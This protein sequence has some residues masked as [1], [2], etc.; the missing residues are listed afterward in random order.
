MK[1]FKAYIFLF[2]CS[3]ILV[4]CKPKAKFEE[5]IEAKREDLL[6]TDKEFSILCQQEGYSR[7]YLEYIDS[8]GILLFP[9]SM[10]LRGGEAIDEILKTSDEG[11]VMQWEPKEAVV[12]AS[13]DIGY[14]YGVYRIDPVTG[15]EPVYGTYATI[16][17]RQ[18]G[19]KWKFLLHTSNQGIEMP[20]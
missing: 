4:A 9:N 7:S 12:A 11:Y 20:E 2:V 17:R 6:L 15:N 16:W 5:T 14:T 13:N 10:P 18:A 8:N 1:F 3:G 19:G